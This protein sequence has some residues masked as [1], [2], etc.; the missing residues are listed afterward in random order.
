MLLERG[1]AVRMVAA[2]IDLNPVRAGLCENPEDYRWCSYAAAVAGEKEARRGLAHAFG[3]VKWT[4]KLAGDYRMILFG[5]GQEVVGGATPRGYVAPKR[6]FARERVREEL[7]RGGRLPLHLPLRCRVRYFT[8][9]VVLG[10]Q[11]L[12]RGL[13]REE[14]RVFRTAAQDQGPADARGRLGRGSDA[15]G[16]AGRCDRG[17]ILSLINFKHTDQVPS[18]SAAEPR[19]NAGERRSMIRRVSFTLWSD[20]FPSFALPEALSPVPS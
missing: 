2:Y 19:V 17:V 18:A 16:S 20:V 3:R 5:Q 6:G 4:A 14:A 15:A 8:D 7:E 1:E 10:E 13:L 12:S 11:R 9:G